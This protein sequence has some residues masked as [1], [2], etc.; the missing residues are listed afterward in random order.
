M[1]YQ[2]ETNLKRL[3]RFAAFQ[4]LAKI[5]L[6][7]EN[8]FSWAENSRRINSNLEDLGPRRITARPEFEVIKI[9]SNSS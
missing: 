6:E 8:V 7:L 1:S 3:V 5:G 9:C 4:D 2:N